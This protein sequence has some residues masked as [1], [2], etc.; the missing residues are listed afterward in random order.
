MFG[1]AIPGKEVELG[2]DKLIPG[3]KSYSAPN[4]VY[5]FMDVDKNVD[6][7]IN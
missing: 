1:Q 4:T 6:I 2:F 3:I 5:R 7:K